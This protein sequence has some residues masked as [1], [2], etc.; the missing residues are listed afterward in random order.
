MKR[1]LITGITG[2]D[3]AFLAKLLLDKE[4]TVYGGIRRVASATTDRLERLGIANRILFKNLD[5]LEESSIVSAVKETKPDEVYN[6]AAQSFVKESFNTPIYTCNVTGLGALRL[7]EAVRQYAPE[8]R[9]YQA[10]S[11]EMFGNNK[12]APQNEKTPFKPASPYGAAKIFAHNM[13]VNYRES[14]GM[15]CSCGILF[16]HESEYRG[17]KFVTRKITRAVALRNFPIKLGNLDSKRDWGH[18]ED[19]VRAMWLMLQQEQPDD[20]VIATGVCRTVREFAEQ[21]LQCIGTVVDWSGEGLE[22]KGINRE[23]GETLIKIDPDYYRPLDLHSLR[24]DYTNARKV[25]GWEPTI[26]FGGL[27]QRMVD[28]DS[29]FLVNS[30]LGNG[31]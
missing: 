21:T 28:F 30:V 8:A 20:Y 23:T 16:N 6:L 18:A 22:E 3:G 19:Y 4:Y 12:N 13:T 29:K 2:Q 15:H 9:Y 24:G 11:S 27:V 31:K 5:M 25:L 10:S 14:Y 26:S 17:L 1:A 7:L